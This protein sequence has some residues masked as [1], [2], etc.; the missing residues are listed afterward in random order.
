VHLLEA[1]QGIEYVADRLGHRNVQNTRIYAQITTSLRQEEFSK[2]ERQHPS[3]NLAK[4]RY[5]GLNS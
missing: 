2:L 3:Y 5:R 1:G 4:Y